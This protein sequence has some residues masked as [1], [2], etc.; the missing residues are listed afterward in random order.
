MTQAP[1]ATPDARLFDEVTAA[2]RRTPKMLPSKL[3]YDTRGAELFEQIMTLPEYY[4]TRTELGILDANAQ[5][6][7]SWIGA[8]ARIVEF[9]SGS[10]DKTR[11]LLEHLATP[12]EY[13]PIDIAAAQLNEFAASLRL[14]FPD[15][16]VRP[17]VADY[18][19]GLRLPP[20][21]PESGRTIVFFPGSTIGNFEPD[22]ASSFLHSAAQLSGPGAGLLI[23]VDLR[24][25]PALIERA[26]NDA[27]GVTAA[28]NRNILNHV[29]R[30]FAGNFD[31]DAFH[32]RAFFN[33]A[34]GRIEMRLVSGRVQ[35]ATLNGPD[36]RETMFEFAEGEELVTEYSYKYTV[37]EFVRLAQAV[38]FQWRH[39]WTDEAQLFG[40]LAFDVE[41]V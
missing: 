4:P 34:R 36:G 10:G 8:Q 22:A 39:T 24:K 23:G 31:P 33:D 28:F 25:D 26:Y 17:I 15:L 41:R 5:A 14:E 29:N 20:R 19:R 27:A 40:E 1:A 21:V 35:S 11:L 37:E 9:G 16:R 7:S 6:I 13:L 18:T 38:G 2:L 32:H 30:L 3:F 12:S